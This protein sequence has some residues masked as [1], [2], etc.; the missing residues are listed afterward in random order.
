MEMKKIA[1][2]VIFTAASIGAAL[3]REGYQYSPAP[4]PAPG[5]STGGSASCLPLVGSWLVLLLPPSSP[6]TCS[7]TRISGRN[8]VDFVGE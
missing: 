4:A 8:G 5:P 6:T 1:C 3:S 7:A 2:A